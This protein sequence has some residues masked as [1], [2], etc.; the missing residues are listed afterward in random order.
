V[1]LLPGDAV[2]R[3]DAAAAGLSMVGG[4]TVDVV[5]GEVRLVD[6]PRGRRNGRR[7]VDSAGGRLNVGVAS[8]A[9]EYRSLDSRKMSLR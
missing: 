9:A 8:T 3:T 7:V 4:P 2:E 6:G 1:G 5:S